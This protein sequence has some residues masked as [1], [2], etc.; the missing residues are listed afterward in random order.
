MQN[1][2]Q[3]LQRIIGEVKGA[4]ANMASA[5][6]E[7][8]ANSTL[9]S[10]GASEQAGKA[11]LV[12]SA[13][14][15]MSQTILDVARNTSGIEASATETVKLAREGE[16]VVDDSVYKVKSIAQTIET[17]ARLIGALGG[18]SDQIGQI[19]NV[20]NDVADQTNLLALNAA[21]EAARAGEAGRGFAVVADEVKKLAERTGNS[22]AEIDS[23]IKSMQKEVREVVATMETITGEVKAGVELSTQAGDVLRSIVASVDQ[24]HVMVQQIASASEEM[25]STSEQISKDI[26]SIATV[27][28]ETSEG[29]EGITRASLE[30]AGLSVDLE[31]S[32][33]GFS[34]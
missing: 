7:L 3:N 10:T 4:A 11:S 13:S 1:M 26:E 8:N 20:I 29:S 28:K 32:V 33:S 31:K 17:S 24:L 19:I 18:R 34:V 30:L 9:M 22:T 27:S 25:A 12:A 14:E 23:M 16:K 6:Q 2:V 15:E 5:S 21:I